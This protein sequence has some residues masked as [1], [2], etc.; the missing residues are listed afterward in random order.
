M[1]NEVL[2]SLLREYSQKKLKAE[3]DLN[4]RKNSL[5]SLLPKL[6]EIENELNSFAI[7]TTK[8]VINKSNNSKYTVNEL[9]NKIET[10]KK[11]KE[12][13]LLD[14]NYTLDYLEPNYECKLCNDTGF[15]VD[16]KY[17]TTMCSCLKQKLIDVS[18]NKSNIYNLKNENFD[19]FNEKIFS[20]KIDKNKYDISPR[21]NILKIKNKCIEF[22]DNFDKPE[23]KNLLFSGSTGLR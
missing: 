21:D 13:I 14:N 19:S 6:S 12:K 23:T 22:I 8:N 11:E 5:F 16:E 17:T 18:I 7:Q 4:N 10:L 20:N 9:K 3:I 1:A 2:N 15:I